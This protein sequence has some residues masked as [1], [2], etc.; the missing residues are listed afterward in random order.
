LEGLA[1]EQVLRKACALAWGDPAVLPNALMERL[2]EREARM[3]AQAGTERQAP[4]TDLNACAEA[5]RRDRTKREL[6]EIDREILSLAAK[7][8][9]SA[10]LTELVMKKIAMRRQL[11]ET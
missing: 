10:R 6:A 1:S 5:L 9:G 2:T 3:L 4:V 8:P 11:G 7:D